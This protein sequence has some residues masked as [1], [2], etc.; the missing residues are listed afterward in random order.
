MTEESN[1][2][3]ERA[4]ELAQMPAQQLLGYIAALLE[5]VAVNQVRSATEVLDKLD[6]P[7]EVWGTVSVD[8]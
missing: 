2:I 7:F 1:K 6:G 8:N 3:D 5:V 4:A